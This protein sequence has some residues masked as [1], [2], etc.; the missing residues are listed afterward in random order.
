MGF[1]NLCAECFL[2]AP[3][4]LDVKLACNLFARLYRMRFRCLGLSMEEPEA[5]L[6]V[7]WQNRAATALGLLRRWLS[8]Q[9]WQEVQPWS[10][11]NT[12]RHCLQAEKTLSLLA[13]DMQKQLHAI[14]YHWRAQHFLE[15]SV[16]HRHEARDLA[17]VTSTTKS[18]EPSSRVK[19]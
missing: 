11:R 3:L 5:Q 6:L 10:W 12:N 7:R 17:P 1:R 2:V 4:H 19:P 8:Q 14:R 13:N 9:G 18:H 16:G 15:W